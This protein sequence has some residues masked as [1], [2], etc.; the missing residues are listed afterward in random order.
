MNAEPLQSPVDR[1]IDALAA[2][3]RPVT[4]LPSPWQRALT[5]LGLFALAAMVAIALSDIGVLLARYSGRELQLAAEMASILATGC[6]AITGAFF[7]AVPGRSRLWLAAPLPFLACWLLLS[8]TGCY[9]AGL[10]RWELGDSLHCL[11]FITGT[12]AALSIPLVWGLSRARP[13]DALQVALL[14]GLGVAALSTFLLHFYHPFD[15]TILDIV[16]HLAAI[17]LVTGAMAL[18]RRR[19]LS[20]A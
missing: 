12:S 10:F 19:T 11:L 13:I 20:P 3:A 2:D 18:L 8:G 4:P 15:V 9:R 16:I 7:V 17:L 5:A 14:G 6:V 1:I